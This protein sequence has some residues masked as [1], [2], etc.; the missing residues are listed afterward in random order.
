MCLSRNHTCRSFTQAAMIA[1]HLGQS[2]DQFSVDHTKS[3]SRHKGFRLLK[4]NTGTK[5]WP[6]TKV[7]GIITALEA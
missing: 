7:W 5:V 2:L 6:I 4:D 3:F 1:A